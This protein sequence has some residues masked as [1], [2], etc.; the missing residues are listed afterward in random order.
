MT[1]PHPEQALLPVIMQANEDARRQFVPGTTNWAYFIAR[2]VVAAL[3]P[4]AAPAEQPEAATIRN[5]RTVAAEPVAAPV[6]PVALTDERIDHIADLVARGMPDG[7]RGFCKTW[8][9]QQFA[10]ALLQDCAGH[11][12]T[13]PVSVERDAA[14]AARYR[15]LRDVGDATWRPFGIREGYSAAQ[16]DAAIDAALAQAGDKP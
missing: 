12:A 6:Q 3:R 5:S 15:W 4:Q 10:R 2:R 11:Y 16:A 8:G 9:W 14:D 1:T 7:I 13:P